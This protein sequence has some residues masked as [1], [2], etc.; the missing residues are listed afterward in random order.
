MA[1][2]RGMISVEGRWHARKE[3]PADLFAI[4]GKETLKEALRTWGLTVAKVL[5]RPGSRRSSRT[6]G[7]SWSRSPK[8][9]KASGRPWRTS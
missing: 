8:P 2:P 1:R 3:V 9:S 4:V 7:P 5:S 6:P